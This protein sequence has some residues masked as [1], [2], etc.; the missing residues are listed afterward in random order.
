MR[1]T[2]VMLSNTLDYNAPSDIGMEF[3]FIPGERFTCWYG[4]QPE[5]GIELNPI[6]SVGL[7]VCSH[8]SQPSCT[9]WRRYIFVINVVKESESC[10]VL[11]DSLW[12]N[13][14]GQNTG[15][16]SLSLP[17]GIFP[18]QGSNPG[19]PCCRQILYQ[20]SHKESSRILEWVAYPFSRASSQPRNGTRVFHIAGGFFTNWGIRKAHPCC[21]CCYWTVCVDYDLGNTWV[22][23]KRD[24]S[25]LAKNWTWVAWMKTGNV[26]IR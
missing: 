12:I 6:S 25:S 10:L 16:G 17:P 23:L 24:L 1:E 18:T 2:P 21:N 5:Q 19:L 9:H 3:F 11:S 26:T 20:L 22:V 4:Q 14:P 13:S 7:S 8:L 15:A